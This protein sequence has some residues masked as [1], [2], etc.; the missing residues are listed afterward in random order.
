MDT[1]T[2]EKRFDVI[3]YN[4]ETREV[5]SVAGKDLA[6]DDGFYNAQKRLQTVIPRLNDRYNGAI[7]PTGKFAVGALYPKKP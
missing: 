4:I 5:D 2:K 6:M 1:K 7:V 3:I